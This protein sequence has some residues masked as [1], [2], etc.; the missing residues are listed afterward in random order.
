M[1]D[2]ANDI[3]EK[4]QNGDKA[5]FEQLYDRY[6]DALYGMVIRMVKDEDLAKDV[7]QESFIKIWKNA[8]KY[9]S[10]KASIF[11]WMYQVTRNT[12]IDKL[13]QLKSRGDKEK[14]F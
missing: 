5:A 10:H 9:D 7:I 13:R 11:T 4:L 6:A 8:S 12:A 3:G 2:L 14:I 1:K